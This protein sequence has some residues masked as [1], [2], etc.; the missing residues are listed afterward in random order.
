MSKSFEWLWEWA[1]HITDSVIR[2]CNGNSWMF[3]KLVILISIDS[4]IRSQMNWVRL[5]FCQ[6]CLATGHNIAH[7]ISGARV[8]ISPFLWIIHSWLCI[9]KLFCD[10]IRSL[11]YIQYVI[12]AIILIQLIYYSILLFA[13]ARFTQNNSSIWSGLRRKKTMVQ[14][15]VLIRK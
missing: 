11:H 14:F 13:Y 4:S 9:L 15:S 5:H 12:G 1:K 8:F 10:K 7:A 6:F 3:R 2:S